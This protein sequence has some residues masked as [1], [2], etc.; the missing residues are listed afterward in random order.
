VRAHL[1]RDLD[2]ELTGGPYAVTAARL[3]LSDID[4]H[5]DGSMAFDIR[6]LVSELVTNSVRHAQL[7]PDDSI[8]LKVGITGRH[9]RV[10][11]SDPGPGF[12][13]PADEPTPEEA[14]A[15]GWGIFFVKQ[16]ADRW[17]VE[18]ARS[19]VWFEI[20]RERAEQDRRD[21]TAA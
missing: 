21:Q 15:S 18:R 7:G 3:A 12:D 5:V 1:S 11:V 8:H 4:E 10:E 6:L 13:P 20:E 17:G 14:A 19:C 16:L 2:Y 9:V